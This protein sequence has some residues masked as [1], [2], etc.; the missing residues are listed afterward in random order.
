MQKAMHRFYVGMA[1]CRLIGVLNGDLPMADPT[2]H[3]KYEKIY[4]LIYVVKQKMDTPFS[5]HAGA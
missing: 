3:E 5:R 2:I 4:L 1:V